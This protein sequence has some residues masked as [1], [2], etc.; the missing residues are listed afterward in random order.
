MWKCYFQLQVWGEGILNCTREKVPLVLEISS[1]AKGD[2]LWSGVY[3]VHE[4]AA[5]V[6]LHDG[7]Q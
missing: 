4:L 2:Y 7:L 1:M 6:G 3:N 5:G